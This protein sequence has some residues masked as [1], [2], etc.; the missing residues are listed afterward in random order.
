VEVQE[1]LRQA[2]EFLTG[3]TQPYEV[4][5]AS[6]D[7]AYSAEF[8]WGLILMMRHLLVQVAKSEGKTP[9]ALLAE[10]QTEGG[11]RRMSWTCQGPLIKKRRNLPEGPDVIGHA[12]SHGGRP[13]VGLA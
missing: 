13:R 3:L 4:S 1:A 5:T 8:V 12:R 11:L 9:E 2:G 6:G 10:L 7:P